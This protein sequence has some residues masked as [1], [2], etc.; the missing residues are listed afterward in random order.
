M[1]VPAGSRVHTSR[2]AIPI[3][4]VRED[5]HVMAAHGYQP[6]TAWFDQGVQDHVEILSES[7]TLFRCTP[8]HRVAGLTDVWGGHTP[9]RARDLTQEDRLLFITRAVD[10]VSVLAKTS[11][12]C[13]PALRFSVSR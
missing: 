11:T 13:V 6:V 4:G 10:G 3:D 2:G 12:A 7:G 8:D 9:K 5:D 1:G